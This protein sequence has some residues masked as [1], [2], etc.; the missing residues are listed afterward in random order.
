[1]RLSDWTNLFPGPKNRLRAAAATGEDFFFP[2][3]S[4]DPGRPRLARER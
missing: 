1:M 3:L 2:K 4:C